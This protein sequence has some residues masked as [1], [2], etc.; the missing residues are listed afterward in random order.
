MRFFILLLSFVILLQPA[1]WAMGMPMSPAHQDISEGM[2]TGLVSTPAMALT[3]A[4][5]EQCQANYDEATLAGEMNHNSH[6]RDNNLPTSCHS[7]PSA[8]TLTTAVGVSFSPQYLDVA[9]HAP[10]IS[11]PSRTESP[12]IRPPHSD[13][14]FPG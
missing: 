4:A 1:S 7:A 2:R 8:S 3:A 11:F 14:R 13:I 6:L 10:S 9:Y 5:G 12:E